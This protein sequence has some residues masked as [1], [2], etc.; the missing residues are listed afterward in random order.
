MKAI[1]LILTIKDFSLDKLKISENQ[2]HINF[3]NLYEAN[4]IDE[5]FIVSHHP[6]SVKLSNLTLTPKRMEYLEENSTMKK[7]FRA[8]KEAKGWLP[9]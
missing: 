8:I 4:Y 9:V 1:F 2:L 5:L 3:K 6:V 7:I